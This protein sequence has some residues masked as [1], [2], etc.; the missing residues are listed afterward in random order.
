MLG[1][2]EKNKEEKLGDMIQMY[3]MPYHNGSNSKQ[4]V[5]RHLKIWRGVNYANVV[6]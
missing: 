6:Y 1:K 2:G 4:V 3:S 5:E